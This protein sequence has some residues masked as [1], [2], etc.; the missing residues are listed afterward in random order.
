LVER[1]DKWLQQPGNQA[2]IETMDAATFAGRLKHYGIKAYPE[3]Q[4]VERWVGQFD[5]D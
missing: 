5:A 3:G 1:L 2:A 4:A